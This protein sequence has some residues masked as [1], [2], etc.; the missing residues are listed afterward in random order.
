MQNYCEPQ[1]YASDVFTL[2]YFLLS[3]VLLPI[4]YTY[5]KKFVDSDY[6]DDVAK[7]EYLKYIISFLS[8]SVVFVIFL[9]I[10][11]KDYDKAILTLINSLLLMGVMFSGLLK[12]TMTQFTAV[13]SIN[14]IISILFF[15]FYV[16]KIIKANPESSKNFTKAVRSTRDAAGSAVYMTGKGLDNVGRATAKG[17]HT[18]G[19]ATA[20]G[21]HG[22]GMTLKQKTT[23]IAL[24]TGRRLKKGVN[25]VL[26]MGKHTPHFKYKIY[27]Q[28]NKTQQ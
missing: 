13:I 24:Q 7:K 25:T 4:T 6:K 19:K 9:L 8:C 23:P 12:N 20:K 28:R 26:N 10:V 1:I 15:I 17:I 16:Y 27:S 5:Y 11:V 22:A 21:I 14:L 18:V 3:I 2:V